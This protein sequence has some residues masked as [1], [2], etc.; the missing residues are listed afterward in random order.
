MPNAVTATLLAGIPSEN[1]AFFHRVRFAVGDP[2]AWLSIDLGNGKQRTEFIVRDIEKD[3]AFKQVKADRV[4]C[5]VDYEPAGG[6]SGDRATATAQAVAECVRRA[7]VERVIT[8]RTLPFIFAWHI[9]QAGIA[10]EYSADLGVLDRRVKDAQE[11]A[12]LADAQQAT[13]AAMAMACQTVARATADRD[14]ILMHAG[15]VLTSESL[16][17]MISVYLLDL[18][19][20]TPHDS[21]VASTPHSADCHERGSGPL[22]TGQSV[23]V[24]IFP[25]SLETS[26]WGDCTRSVVHGDIS[27]EMKKMHAAVVDAKAHATLAA[28]A[29]AIADDVH[30]ATKSTLAKHGYPFARGEISDTPIMPHGTGHGIG[31]ECHEP[32]LL[33]D[34]GGTLLLGEVFTIEP[35]L[36]S[37]NFGGVRVEDM[38]VVTEGQ[39]RNL[40]KLPEGLDW[41]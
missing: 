38:V 31:L 14:G 10:V 25:R 1:P 2:A 21:I 17:K 34:R 32:I 15:A 26:Y 35:G 39:P 33:D 23:I 3:R 24:D 28:K 41:R 13:E 40:N 22:H 12:W 11:L 5:P 20:A 30:N 36:Y 6:L 8:D 18:G 29:G 37:R 9:Q 27:D 7:G 4:S 16:R 19:Y